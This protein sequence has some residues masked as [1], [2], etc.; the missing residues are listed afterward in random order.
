LYTK[1]VPCS[2][3]P[4]VYSYVCPTCIL[5]VSSTSQVSTNSGQPR[6]QQSL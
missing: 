6:W 3:N 5:P 1:R 2:R 4:D